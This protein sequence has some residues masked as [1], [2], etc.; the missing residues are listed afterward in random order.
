MLNIARCPV[1]WLQLC[2]YMVLTFLWKYYSSFP[3]LLMDKT[4]ISLQIITVS[5]MQLTKDHWTIHDLSLMS[6][7]VQTLFWYAKAVH[8]KNSSFGNHKSWFFLCWICSNC[9][10][11]IYKFWKN[12][13]KARTDLITLH[14]RQ[15]WDVWCIIFCRSSLCTF[16]IPI[17][18]MQ[19]CYCT[20]FSI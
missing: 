11:F 18:Y 19:E 5:S 13:L 20:L 2:F 3:L 14:K 6:T 9:L 8:L 1:L 10:H 15:N 16:L 7:F 4:C 12:L 17:H